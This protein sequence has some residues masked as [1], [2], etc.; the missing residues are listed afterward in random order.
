MRGL[1]TWVK[2]VLFWSILCQFCVNYLA[3]LK[4]GFFLLGSNMSYFGQFC[5]N[6]LA[7]SKRRGCLLGSYMSHIGQFCANFVWIKGRFLKDRV[8]YLGHISPILVNFRSEEGHFQGIGHWVQYMGPCVTKVITRLNH[9]LMCIQC[10][11]LAK[12]SPLGGQ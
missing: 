9:Q 4:R 8:F 6:L 3:I 7:I 10:L 1:F 11:S 2:Y 12:Y 5:A